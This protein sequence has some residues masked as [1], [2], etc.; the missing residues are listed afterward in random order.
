MKS[1]YLAAALLLCAAPLS[2]AAQQQQLAPA[3]QQAAPAAPAAKAA[4]ARTSEKEAIAAFKTYIEKRAAEGGHSGAVK[5]SKN[6]KTLFEGAYGY[7]DREKKIPNTLDTKFYFASMGKMV[8]GVA[9]TQLIQAGKIKLDDPI[10]KFLP[11][12]PN[13]ELASKATIF[14]LLTHSGGT[15][16][17][18]GPEFRDGAD[19]LKEHADF[20]KLFG[21]RPLLFEPGSKFG[22]SNYGMLI[23]GRIIEV[24]SGQS[25]F[26]Y[27]RENIFKPAGMNS[28]D[29]LPK[30]PAIPGLAVN[31]TK[32]GGETYP[33]G[34]RPSVE[35]L[36]RG[37]AS[38][39]GH[40]TVGDWTRFAEAVMNHKLLDAEHTELYLT[41]KHLPH[42]HRS[43]RWPQGRHAAN[44]AR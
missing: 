2:A 44:A 33:D 18:W 35:P 4:V 16:E 7:A 14:H 40:S 20:I 10:I 25:Y 27:V 28:T 24:V 11:D 12:Y 22:Y 36:Y 29:N 17:I 31:Y 15:G 43:R 32:Q 3:P 38:G 9:I 26:D 19:N 13:K 41:G 5:V 6:G 39:G 23:L 42:R 8:T 21:E 1:N 34:L 30:D 37:M